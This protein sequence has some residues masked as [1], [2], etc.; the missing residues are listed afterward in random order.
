MDLNIVIIN[1]EGGFLWGIIIFIINIELN[2]IIDL[3]ESRFVSL[4]NFFLKDFEIN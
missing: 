4:I 1:F 3:E 2:L